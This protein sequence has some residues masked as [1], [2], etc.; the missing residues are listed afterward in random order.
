MPTALR[1][2]LRHPGDSDDSLSV[3]GYDNTDDP[4][5]MQGACEVLDKRSP[6]EHEHLIPVR[7]LLKGPHLMLSGWL[8][9]LRGETRED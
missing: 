6:Y 4:S 7:R 1:G 9:S 5:Y 3:D 2:H 8:A